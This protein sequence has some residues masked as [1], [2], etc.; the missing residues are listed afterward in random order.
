M[1][2]SRS[3]QLNRTP[4]WHGPVLPFSSWYVGFGRLV[5]YWADCSKLLAGAAYID[6][7]MLKGFNSLC[8]VQLEWQIVE[9]TY[10][11]PSRLAGYQDLIEPISKLYSHI[12]EYQARVICHLSRAQL[13]RAWEKVLGW[14]NWEEKSAEIQDFS[15]QCR[16]YISPLQVQEIQNAK[17]I[18]LQNIQESRTILDKIRMILEEERRTTQKLH[19][20]QKERELLQDLA[21]DYESHKDYNPPRVQGT[22]EWFFEDERFRKWRD[23]DFGLLWVSAGPGSGKSVLSRALIDEHRLSTN[24]TTSAVCYFFFKDG[25]EHR[26]YATNALSAILHQL[27]RHDATGRLIEHALPSHKMF[28]KSL[29]QSFSELWRVL[30]NCVNS[31]DA[32]EV[33]CVLD[34]LDE[35]HPDSRQQLLNKLQ[36]IYCQHPRTSN[37]PPRLK[38]LITSRPYDDLEASFRRFSNTIGYVRFDGDD[39]VAQIR[40][41]INLVIDVK[42][43]EIAYNF[44]EEDRRKIA[45]RLKGMEHRTYLWLHLTFDII[46]QSPS[47]YG[48]RSDVEALLNDLPAEIST[49]YEK[50]LDRSRDKRQTE[51]LLQIV[52]AAARPLTLDEANEALTLALQKEQYDSHAALKSDIWPRGSFKSAVKNLCGLLITVHESKLFLIHQT[53]REFLIHPEPKGRWQGRLNLSKAHGKMTLT[54]LDYLSLLKEQKQIWKVKAEFPF[55]QYSSEYWMDHAKLAQG[56]DDVQRRIMSFFLQERL[57]YN[58]WGDLFDPDNPFVSNPRSF[59]PMAAPLYYAS[60][61]GLQRIV[62]LLLEEGVD[63]NT[64]GGKYGNALQVA[65]LRGEKEVVLLLLERGADINAQAGHY[66]TALQAASA[67]GRRDVVQQLLERGANVNAQGGFYGT[68]I[69]AASDIGDKEVLMLLLERGADVNAQGGFYGTALQAASDRGH[70]EVLLLLLERGADVNAQGGY[71][72]TAL[73]TASLQGNKEVVQLLLEKGANINAQGGTYGTALTAASDH[74][75]KEVVELLLERG[76]DVNAQGGDYGA[77]TPLQAASATGHKEVA[78]LLLEKGA[79]ANAPGGLYGTALQAASQY[80]RKE[81]VRLLLEKGADVNALGGDFGTALQAASY[82]GDKE[83]VQLLLARG[84]NVNLQ[85]GHYGTALQAAS[86]MGHKEVVQLLLNRGADINAQGGIYGNAF[87]AASRLGLQEIVQLLLE[88]GAHNGL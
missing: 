45:D 75:R 28:G 47:E 79:D 56:E 27:F 6:E 21:S 77:V 25:D 80:G 18:E 39:K 67:R 13:S 78:Q 58:I 34:A 7:S 81:V 74:G 11:S 48:K 73:Q 1:L 32:E 38:F 40:N 66:G 19:D 51:I 52:L 83:I 12:L 3:L 55:A 8:D 68:A 14:N 72:G 24:V 63:V 16:R 57:A 30:M 60:S 15:E 4:C 84:A 53:A 26:M 65:S 49:A 22:C 46:Q 42:L 54:C 2:S 76:A 43:D 50:I 71:H 87:Q 10:L 44:D 82:Q 17:N 37:P 31:P 5:R 33:I 9:K 64:R 69:Q 20:S 88:N 85:A 59:G 41:E 61:G 86:A 70:K 23:S 35:C 36:E 29:A 62:E